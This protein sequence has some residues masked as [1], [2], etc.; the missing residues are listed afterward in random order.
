M[1]NFLMAP[2][3]KKTQQATIAPWPEPDAKKQE[4]QSR[5]GGELQVA[6]IGGQ[7]PGA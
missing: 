3:N 7:D 5:F 2:G 1:V 4:L 6:H